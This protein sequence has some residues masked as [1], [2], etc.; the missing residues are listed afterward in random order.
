MEKD[1]KGVAIVGAFALGVLAA[2]AI[3]KFFSEPKE[4]EEKIEK[5]V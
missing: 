4:T 2:F 1:N 3:N 5:K